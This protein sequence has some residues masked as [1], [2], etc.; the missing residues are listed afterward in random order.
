VPLLVYECRGFCAV[1]V[2]PSPKFQAHAVGL[3]RLVSENW[4]GSGRLPLSGDA[5]NDATG[6]TVT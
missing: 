1:L 2:W 3:P 4:T 6:L 5:V